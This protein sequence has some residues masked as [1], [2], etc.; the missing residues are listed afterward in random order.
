MCTRRLLPFGKDIGLLRSG[1]KRR[2][3]RLSKAIAGA[4]PVCGTSLIESLQQHRDGAV[5]FIQQKN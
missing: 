5:E 4:R 3:I 1:R 2:V